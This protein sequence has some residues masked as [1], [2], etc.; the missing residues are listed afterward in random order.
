MTSRLKLVIVCSVLITSVLS[1]C[2]KAPPSLIVDS[3][4]SPTMAES[5]VPQMTALSGER[6]LLSWQRPLPGGGYAFEMA[7]RNGGR[8]SEVRTI[9][10]G[11]ELSMFT[12][13]LPGVATLAATKLLAYWEVKDEGNGDHYATT[14]KMAISIDEG[15]SWLP[16]PTPYSDALA[17]QHSFLSWFGR[18]N[19]IGLLWLDASARSQMRHTLMQKR[20]DKKDSDLG[21]VGLRYAALNAEGR[22]DHEQFV[23][24]ITCEC[25]PTS[26]AST[27][28]GPVVVYRGREEAPGTLPSQSMMI[29]LQ[30]VTSTSCARRVAYG[31]SPIWFTK[32][33]GSS[34][35]ALTTD[36]RW[37]PLR[38]TSRLP[39]GHVQ[40]INRRYR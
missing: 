8:W 4:L 38:I 3:E 33:T 40:T 25:C 16:T 15:R 22:V 14:I 12:A 11:P 2:R 17:G 30:C 27:E 26:A 6:T 28:R 37:M 1:S 35:L 29:G 23:E 36:R 34:T 39:G 24:P 9:A 31:E 10:E 20:A 5:L 7:V 21:S 13:D 19:G 32:I 18:K